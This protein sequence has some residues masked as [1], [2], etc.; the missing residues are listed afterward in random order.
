MKNDRGSR[1][2]K[3]KCYQ[4]KQLRLKKEFR[5]ENA[6]SDGRHRTLSWR[7][8]GNAGCASCGN[9]RRNAWLKKE[10]QRTIQERKHFQDKPE[11]NLD[12]QTDL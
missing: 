1:R 10:E 3:T 4:K 5:L 2:D 9:Q 11:D 12:T 8:C 7:T 6:A